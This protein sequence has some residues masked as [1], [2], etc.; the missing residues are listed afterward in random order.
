MDNQSGTLRYLRGE[1]NTIVENS[2][3]YQIA[4]ID[5]NFSQMGLVL[6][7]EINRV[8]NIQNPS[9]EFNQSRIQVDELGMTHVHY[10]Q[11]YQGVPIWGAQVGVHFSSNK[12][13]VE[14]SGVYTPTPATMQIPQ[15]EISTQTA[16]TKARES[17]NISGQGLL[18]PKVQKMIYWDIDKAAVMSYQVELTPSISEHWLV[19]VSTSNGDIVHQTRNICSAATVGHSADLNG[20][21]QDV[22]GWEDQGTFFSNRHISPHV[23]PGLNTSRYE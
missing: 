13:P 15:Q 3:N 12:E 21:V 5:D 22:H 4:L 16:I 8:M 10:Q 1:L 17:L 6:M 7:D 18:A 11:T 9:K 20:V 14:V 23:R 2:D 19:F